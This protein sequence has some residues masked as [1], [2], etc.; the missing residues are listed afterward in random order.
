MNGLRIPYQAALWTAPASFLF[1]FAAQQYGMFSTP[2][3]LDIHK[4]HLSFFSPQPIFILLFF[5]PQQVCQL[6]WLWRLW[7]LNGQKSAS[8]KREIE[9]IVDYVPF[10]ALGNVCIG[11]WM[12]FWNASSLKM[13]N[14]FVA[15]N[16]CAQLYYIMFRLRAMDMNSRSSILTHIVSK[17]FAGIGV[18]DILHNTSIAYFQD[19]SASSAVRILTGV[20]FGLSCALSDWIFGGCK[21]SIASSSTIANLV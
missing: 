17:T 19:E 6:A 2:N 10:Y 7:R 1:D 18:L 15:V 4:A 11:L 21:V 12:F 8:D 16:T 9:H 13:A 14:F 5:L 3:M 20:G